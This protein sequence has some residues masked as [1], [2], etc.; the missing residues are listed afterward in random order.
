MKF[1]VIYPRISVIIAVFNG[2]STLQQ[3]LDSVTQQVYK[4]VEIIVI[5]GGSTDESVGILKK[6]DSLIDYWISEPD[7]GVYNA[8]NKALEKAGGD[9]ICFLGADDYF[10][11]TDVLTKM[12]DQL[13]RMAKE[14][15]LVYG[16]VMLL[17]AS[18]E[19]IYPIGQ[20]WPDINEQLKKM[21][22]IPHPGAM[23]RK[24]FF[25]DNGSFDESYKISG[26]YELLLRGF[27][28][29]GATVSFVLNLVTVGMRHGGLSS[30]PKNSLLAM[31]E[32]R[33]AQK[34][35]YKGL[36]GRAWVLG[37]IRIYV[38]S[39][40]WRLL[41]EEFGKKVMDAGRRIKGLPPYWS[42]V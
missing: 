19:S 35:Y 28:K 32:I 6:N 14:T 29:S 39:L 17:T 20:A 11:D 15:S 9:W 1:D 22:C 33:R 41:G 37:L 27:S 21:M 7:R 26:D 40:V 4:N 16:Q 2:Q 5:D 30:D 34:K 3:C 24:S 38:R 12:A 36:P 31:W 23:H 18:G 25:D 42:K 13:C 10:W 8:W